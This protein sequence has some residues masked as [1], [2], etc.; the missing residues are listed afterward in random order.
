MVSLDG[1][2]GKIKGRIL[3]AAADSFSRSGFSGASTR[4]IASSAGVNEVTIY[5]HY[6]RKRD[7]YLAV[8]AQELSRVHLRGDQL[9]EVAEA[10]DARQALMRVFTL[11]ETAVL[12]QPLVLPLILYGALESATDVD[13]LLRRHLGEFLAIVAR[14]L[15]PW[16]DEGKVV[17]QGAR[18]TAMALVSIM[19]FRQSLRRVFPETANTANT[20][21]ALADVYTGAFR[22]SIGEPAETR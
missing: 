11:I 3:A 16:I 9:Q 20:V 7:L 5:R 14:Y 2:G 12:E 19:V 21:G 13:T 6:P 22:R 10:A 8:L 1:N 4:E 17:S 18:E 15:E